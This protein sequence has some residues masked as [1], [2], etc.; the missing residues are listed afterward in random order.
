M[1]HSSVSRFPGIVMIS[2]L[3]FLISF[4]WRMIISSTFFIIKRLALACIMAHS[5]CRNQKFYPGNQI[6]LNPRSKSC[7][8]NLCFIRKQLDMSRIGVMHHIDSFVHAGWKTLPPEKS[9]K[10]Q[11]AHADHQRHLFL[12][13]PDKTVLCIFPIGKPPLKY[14]CVISWVVKSK[15][16][17]ISPSAAICSMMLRLHRWNETDRLYTK[18]FQ[19]INGSTRPCVRNPHQSHA[20]NRLI[21]FFRTWPACF[22]IPAQHAHAFA[23]IC[24]VT[25]LSPVK[26]HMD[27]IVTISFAPTTLQM[28]CGLMPPWLP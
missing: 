13:P 23:M 3:G 26:S 2:T 9:I 14:S 24:L 6:F 5:V 21:A 4:N 20:H 22:T 12:H 16:P 8:C 11:A 15:I 10:I 1:P 17:S 18:P 28:F 25:M 19:L 7:C 27:G